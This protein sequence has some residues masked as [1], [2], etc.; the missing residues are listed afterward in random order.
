MYRDKAGNYTFSFVYYHTMPPI[1]CLEKN[2][3]VDQIVNGHWRWSYERISQGKE[4]KRKN[5]Y[6]KS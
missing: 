2:G 4:R 1:Y 6:G 3:A 5:D